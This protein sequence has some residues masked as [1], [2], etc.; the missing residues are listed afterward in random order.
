MRTPIKV[1]VAGLGHAG[2]L[3]ARMFRDSAQADVSWLCDEE[4][5]TRLALRT[6]YPRARM[7]ANF[8][9]L[10][11]DDDVDAIVLATPSATHAHLVERSLA[12]D[13][14]VFVERLLALRSE[15]ADRLVLH[16]ERESRCLM[17]GQA[18]LFDPAVAHAKELIESGRLGDLFYLST[19]RHNFGSRREDENVLWGLGTDDVWVLLHLLADQPIAVSA[20][21]DC[22]LQEGVTDVASCYLRFATGI[23]V[24][25]HLS[26]LDPH[27]IQRLTAVG[28]EGTAVIDHQK[29]ERKLTIYRKRV[30]SPGPSRFSKSLGM[31]QGDI[32]SPELP[33]EDPL[34][35][36]CEHFISSIRSGSAVSSARAGAGVVT[37]LESLQR[38]LDA[39]GSTET[40][41]DH[42]PRNRLA[43]VLPIAIEQ[44]Q[45]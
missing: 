35:L 18:R 13:K 42:W 7:T 19:H 21:G 24:H 28:S 3:L 25:M 12:A 6:R 17:V 23:G 15:E 10:L 30:A 9:D 36:Q 27:E 14:H 22:Y 34:R 44:T 41:T 4:P 29:T 43:P 31:Q 11:D 45:G 16:A 20:C 40:V 32:V 39:Q 2:L 8:D 5:E 38:S 37:V 33:A 26:W 1:A